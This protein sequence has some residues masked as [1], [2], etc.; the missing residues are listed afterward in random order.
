MIESI[1]ENASTP[2]DNQNYN[3]TGYFDIS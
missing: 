1:K 2:Q 3:G